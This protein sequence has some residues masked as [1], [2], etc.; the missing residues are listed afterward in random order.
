[1]KTSHREPSLVVLALPGSESIAI[2]LAE[3]MH[4][5]LGAV[6]FHTFPDGESYVRIDDDVAAR[7]VVIVASLREPNEK[8]VNLVFLSDAA[9]DMGATRVG[10]IAPYL[11][12]LRQDTR[13]H[14]GEAITART[15]AAML[16]AHVDWLVTVDPHLHRFASLAELF[17]IPALNVHAG[18]EIGRWIGRN[19]AAPFIIGPDAESRQWVERIASAADAPFTVLTKIRRGDTKVIESVPDLGE[20]R[21]CTPVLVDDIIST[22]HTMIAAVRHLRDQAALPPVCVATH[23]VFAADAEAQ[24][25]AAG[26]ARVVTT[27]TIVHQTNAIDIV[28]MI[29]A[30][31]LVERSMLDRASRSEAVGT[32]P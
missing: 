19:V 7:E 2:R 6:H 10:L 17:S 16:S 25:E 3:G 30:A 32:G 24:L 18:S 13:F 15:V 27:N 31:A 1:M 12:Y 9:R 4:A 21:S 22:G 14:P 20:H 11:A 5:T 28:P 26:A 8:L 29:A 23:A